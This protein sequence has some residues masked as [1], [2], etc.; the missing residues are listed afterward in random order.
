[1]GPHVSP[2]R[3]EAI[4]QRIAEVLK[5]E[6]HIDLEFNTSEKNPAVFGVGDA[7]VW[8]RLESDLR[9][10]LLEIYTQQCYDSF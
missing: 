6:F 2:K 10:A 5:S 9:E 8:K 3:I 4:H 1:M 7:E